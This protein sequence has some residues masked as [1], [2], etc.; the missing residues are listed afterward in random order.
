M[1]TTQARTKLE[2]ER[3]HLLRLRDEEVENTGLHEE[4]SESSGTLADYDQHPGDVGTETFERTKELAVQDQLDDRLSEV[5]AALERLEEGNYGRCEVCGRQ[6][7]PER[8]EAR[9]ATRYCVEHQA[10]A[11]DEAAAVR[12]EEGPF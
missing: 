8:L 10:E 11:D 6:I 7:D 1:D 9:P 5:N 2:E 3:E 4:Q 12:E